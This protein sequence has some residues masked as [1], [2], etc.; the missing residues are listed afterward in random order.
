VVNSGRAERRSADQREDQWE[1][2]FHR[3]SPSA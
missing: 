3:Y 2:Q 1:I